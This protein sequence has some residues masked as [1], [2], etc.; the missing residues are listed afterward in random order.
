MKQQQ[1]NSAEVY[2]CIH[3]SMKIGAEFSQVMHWKLSEIQCGA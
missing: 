1:R 2:A 3:L